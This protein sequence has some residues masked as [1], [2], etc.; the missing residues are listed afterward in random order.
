MTS[1]AARAYGWQQAQQFLVWLQTQR[2]APPSAPKTCSERSGRGV[3]NDAQFLAEL[4]T[5]YGTDS[6]TT[7]EVAALRRVNRSSVN[8]YLQRLWRGGALTRR[9]QNDNG[10]HGGRP[11]YYYTVKY[12]VESV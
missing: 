4:C 10:V 7:D 8:K 1:I 9:S 11:T 12:T 3:K 2:S 6:F 5:H